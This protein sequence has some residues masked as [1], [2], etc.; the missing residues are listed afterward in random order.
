MM[1]KLW[2]F[3]IVLQVNCN[4]LNIPRPE[5]GQTQKVQSEV[6]TKVGLVNAEASIF[7]WNN[8][9]EG[10]SEKILLKC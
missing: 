2:N 1:Q 4:I 5:F 10:N 6:Y 3:L 7:V 8:T 9:F